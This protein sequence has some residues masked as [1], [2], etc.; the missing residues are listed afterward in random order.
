MWKLNPWLALAVFV[1]LC[2]AA[3][4]IGGLAT[5]QSVTDWYP[6]LAKPAWNPPSWVFAP[7]WTT[8]Y[9]LMA[10]AAWLVWR[11][12]PAAKFALRMFVVQLVLNVAWSFLF[13]GA[14]SPGLAVAEIVVLWLAIMATTRAFFRLSQPAGLLM[15]PYIAWV[16]FAAVLN[17]AVWRLN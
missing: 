10:L 13:F 8:L 9:V 4:A 15:L 12:G 1:V 11:K 5:A 16:S 17:L 6:T 2:L 14:R 3:G 7:V